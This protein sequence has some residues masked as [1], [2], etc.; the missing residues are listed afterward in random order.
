M[1]KLNQK[2]SLGVT[3]DKLI[4]EYACSKVVEPRMSSKCLL[5]DALLL[6]FDFTLLD[7]LI[8]T[9]IMPHY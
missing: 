9:S 3:S 1:R 6:S 7:A 5:R 8:F 2:H 4:L